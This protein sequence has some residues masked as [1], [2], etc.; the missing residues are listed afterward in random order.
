VKVIC[1]AEAEAEKLF[2]GDEGH[3]EDRQSIIYDELS[4]THLGTIWNGEEEK[5]IFNRAVSRLT[6]M[7][8]SE[9]LQSPHKPDQ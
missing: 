9:Y 4:G 5:F 6:E 8:S 3:D 1:S 7:Q 2:S